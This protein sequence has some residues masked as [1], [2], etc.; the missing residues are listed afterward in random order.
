MWHWR[1]KV[2]VVVA[3][4]AAMVALGATLE[5]SNALFNDEPTVPA[6]SVTTKD[7]FP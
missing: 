1:R 6:N 4:A 3:A 5:R 7:S 2:A